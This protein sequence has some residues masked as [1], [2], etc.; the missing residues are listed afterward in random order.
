MDVVEL[1]GDGLQAGEE[2]VADGEFDRLRVRQ[3]P[4]DA[5]QQFGLTIVNDVVWHANAPLGKEFHPC[6]SFQS[7]PL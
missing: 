5:I 4:L 3:F 2:E 6:R 7:K 1:V